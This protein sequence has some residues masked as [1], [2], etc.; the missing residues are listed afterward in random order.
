LKRRTSIN[1]I[2]QTHKEKEMA[3]FRKLIYAL[4]LVAMLAGLTIPASAQA[5]PFVCLTNG[6]VPPI[7]RA[8]GYTELV[9]DLTL[10]CTGGVPTP[11]GQVV[12]QVNFQIFMN[13]GVTSKLLTLTGGWTEALLIVDEPHSAVN[14]SRPILNCGATG[15]PDNGPSGAGVCSITSDGIALDS[16]NGTPGT[17]T[18]GTGHPNVF[19]ARWSA[20]QS[21]ALFW[22][23]VPLDP[24]GTTTTRTVRFTNIRVDAEQFGLSTG[25]ATISV[26]AQVSVTGTTSLLINNPSQVV[27]YVQQG[28]RVSGPLSASSFLQCNSENATGPGN[29]FS[30]GTG[31]GPLGTSSTTPPFTTNGLSGQTSKI[32]AAIMKFTEGFASSWKTK[33]ISYVTNQGGNGTIT[34]GAGYWKYNG[35]YNTPA[36]QNQ[37]VPGAIYNTESGFENG[38]PSLDPAAPGNPPQ[39]TGTS[40]VTPGLGGAFSSTSTGIAGAGIASAGTRLAVQ[41]TNIP[42]NSIVLI[43]QAIPLMVGTTQTGVAVVTSTD[44]AGAGIVNIPSAPT[45]GT[46]VNTYV[47]LPANGLAVYEVLWAD[48]F[49]TETASVPLVVAYT[50]TA[51]SQAASGGPATQGFGSFAPFYQTSSAIAP[52]LA[53]STAPIPRFNPSVTGLTPVNLYTVSKCSCNVLF[54]WTVS[55]GGFDTGIAIANA[56]K[57]DLGGPGVSLASI[58]SGPVQFWYYGTGTGTSSA[59][60]S[61]Q[62][63]NTTSPGTC[64]GTMNVPGGQVLTYVLSTGSSQWG[65]DARA[66]GF[67]GYMIAQASFQYCHAFAYI[68]ALG[69][70]PLT[71]GISEGYVGLLLDTAGGLGRTTNPSESLGR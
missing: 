48:P 4:A 25:F 20:S 70:G 6:G 19:Q 66:A 38:S 40:I 2:F 1:S 10:N 16:Y 23:G 62:C 57:D 55:A 7:I 44:N 35:T 58:Q 68:S 33:N 39:G 22:N 14:P 13:T 32:P 36:D 56:S 15:A 24:P 63:T 41:V 46:Y 12:P 59:P 67:Y 54:P 29:P 51:T 50:Y 27:A 49:S 64:P 69:A 34:A 31:Q 26:I 17:G 45:T 47:T 37:N 8:E 18:Y 60:P 5:N 61:T 53:S 21:N 11:A 43:P 30:T 9:G 28:L 71:T 52:R 3:D 42:A 65:L